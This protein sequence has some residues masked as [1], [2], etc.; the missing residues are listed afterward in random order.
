MM[1]LIYAGY[2]DGY[3]QEICLQELNFMHNA[4]K[5]HPLYIMTQ[6]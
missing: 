6:K 4:K 3:V 1:A 2:M 5:Y